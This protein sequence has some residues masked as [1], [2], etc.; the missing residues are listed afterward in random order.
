MSS[1]KPTAAGNMHIY[2]VCQI[3]AVNKQLISLLSWNNPL[4]ER[5]FGESYILP[6]DRYLDAKKK[7]SLDVERAYNM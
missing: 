2:A 5:S 7:H 1:G 3:D 6:I 4:S